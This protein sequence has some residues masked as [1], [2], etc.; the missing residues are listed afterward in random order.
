MRG[1][2]KVAGGVAFVTFTARGRVGLGARRL[3][4]TGVTRG[5]VR[6]D[7]VGAVPFVVGVVVG[8]AKFTGRRPAGLGDGLRTDLTRETGVVGGS[9]VSTAEVDTV[10]VDFDDTDRAGATLGCLRGLY[11]STL[12]KSG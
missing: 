2:A 7:A 8:V 9:I 11:A 6:G 10:A 1:L 4:A 12:T 5:S 3:G